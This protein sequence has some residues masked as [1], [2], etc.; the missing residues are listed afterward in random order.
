[1][2]GCGHGR[3][4]SAHR[5][6]ETEIEAHQTVHRVE[7]ELHLVLEEHHVDKTLFSHERSAQK[8]VRYF[9]YLEHFLRLVTL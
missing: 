9:I 8:T 1:L 2:A 5:Q 7:Q 6:S 3:E 4:F